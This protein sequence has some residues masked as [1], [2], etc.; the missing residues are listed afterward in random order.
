M[1]KM[2]LSHKADTTA[3]GGVNIARSLNWRPDPLRNLK[4]SRYFL[5]GFGKSWAQGS[6]EGSGNGEEEGWKGYIIGS[7]LAVSIL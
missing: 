7:G 4:R 2:L 3:Q 6:K 5:A 1:I